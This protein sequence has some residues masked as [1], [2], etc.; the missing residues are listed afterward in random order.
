MAEDRSQLHTR[1]TLLARIRDPRDGEAWRQF[2]ESYAPLVYGYC[3]RRGLGE[4]DAADVGQIV[5]T[6][7]SRAI[8]G[9]E[10]DPQRGKF[11]HWLGAIVRNEIHR[12]K[13][14]D[15][16]REQAEGAGEDDLLNHVADSGE[17][18]EWVEQF[19]RHVFQLA[20]ERTRGHFEEPTWRAFEL[21]WFENRPAAEV[22]KELNLAVD[23]VYEAKARVLRRLREEVLL[24][25]EE[26]P[27]L[28]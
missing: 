3:R 25:A 23:R 8:A 20:Q 22:A 6:R 5:F 2:V 4:F 18:P 9:F 14:K 11:R 13:A 1:P 10:Y 15:R 12:F 16:R 27:V 7:I 19:N 26:A 17:D 28:G 21:L 24:L